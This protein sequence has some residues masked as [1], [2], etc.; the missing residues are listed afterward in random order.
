VTKD[1]VEN[2]EKEKHSSIDGGIAS[3]YNYTG[4]QFCGSSEN[5]TYFTERSSNTTPGNIPQRCS[6]L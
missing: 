4:N 5:W 6:N 2:V 1:A 3:W